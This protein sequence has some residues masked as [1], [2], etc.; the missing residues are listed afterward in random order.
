MC[1]GA[2]DGPV[3]L[4]SWTLVRLQRQHRR[5][6]RSVRRRGHHRL[7]DRRDRGARH[8]GE[9]SGRL[10]GAASEARVVSV[11]K[12]AIESPTLEDVALLV[13]VASRGRGRDR[14]AEASAADQKSGED[15]HSSRRHA[16]V[17]SGLR[18]LD[19]SDAVGCDGHRHR[20][21]ASRRDPS[22]MRESTRR[23][24]YVLSRSSGSRRG[25]GSASLCDASDR[26]A[27]SDAR[28]PR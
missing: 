1:E 4:T 9:S 24:V 18:G 11:E 3:S 27:M 20:D 14:G 25:R 22:A 23:S 15:A 19:A 7:A 8:A 5:R 6:T 16:H 17:A 26:R 12:E 28:M 2:A 21:E 13:D 10:D